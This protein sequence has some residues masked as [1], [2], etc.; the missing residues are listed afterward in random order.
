MALTFD[1]GGGKFSID[2][3]QIEI[4]A[5]GSLKIETGAN[6]DLEAGGQVNIKGAMINLN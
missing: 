5:S 3:N 2:G 6:I 1:D 4:K